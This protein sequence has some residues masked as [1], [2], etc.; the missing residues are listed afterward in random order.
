MVC[1][2]V[3]VTDT[4]KMDAVIAPGKKTTKSAG[5]GHVFGKD[6]QQKG[7]SVEQYRIIDIPLSSQQRQITKHT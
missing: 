4:S 3:V 2:A 5:D 1:Q 7:G 6:L